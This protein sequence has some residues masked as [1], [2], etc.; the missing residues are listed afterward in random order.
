MKLSTYK[1][2]KRNIII[3]VVFVALISFLGTVIFYWFQKTPK[4]FDNNKSEQDEP[5][6][7]N[8]DDVSPWTKKNPYLNKRFP[9]ESDILITSTG[10]MLTLPKE[11]TLPYSIFNQNDYWATIPQDEQNKQGLEDLKSYVK[12]YKTYKSESIGQFDSLTLQSKK[13]N[14]EFKISKSEIVLVSKGENYF[15]GAYEY[16]T[17][18]TFLITNKF[19][20]FTYPSSRVPY[21]PKYIK[22]ISMD[23]EYDEDFFFVWG[24]SLFS[25]IAN[26]KTQ[27]AYL[28]QGF[29]TEKGLYNE[30][31]LFLYKPKNYIDRLTPKDKYNNNTI[32]R[33]KD[34]IINNINYDLSEMYLDIGIG[35]YISLVY[36]PTNNV[37][38]DYVRTIVID[39]K[40]YRNSFI[41]VSYSSKRLYE[42]Y[43]DSPCSA[44]VYDTVNLSENDLIPFGK[45]SRGIQY[46][47][48]A[49]SDQLN[50]HC[51][52]KKTNFA[53]RIYQYSIATLPSKE[54]D[55]CAHVESY[56]NELNSITDFKY[57]D[58]NSNQESENIDQ[59]S[60][61]TFN[62]IL[63]VRD[64]FGKMI[65]LH[66]M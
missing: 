35:Y 29:E 6:Q 15:I 58:E 22:P 21:D 24:S 16:S 46:F 50:I 62:P 3:L 51:T 13:T 57:D 4:Y 61:E 39:S 27:P 55:Y 11:F 56:K 17:K 47:T 10:L 34:E 63:F 54:N 28:I 9:T 14:K 43:G 26:S 36:S 64:G 66:P 19:P 37:E 59:S 1:L 42:C 31:G 32:Y 2:D 38:F 45:D 20:G 5:R 52:T 7:P 12:K 60:N 44:I 53:S 8:V 18:L 23:N 33:I 25:A 49:K 30:Y 65:R 48:A 41:S 40:D